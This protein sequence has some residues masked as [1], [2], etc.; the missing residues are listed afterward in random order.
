MSNMRENPNEI[1]DKTRNSKA[2]TL[3]VKNREN[4]GHLK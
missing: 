3:N 4:L 1:M 2:E